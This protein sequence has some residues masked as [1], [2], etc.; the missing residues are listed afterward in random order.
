[1]RYLIISYDDYFN[2]P[3]IKFYEEYLSKH[4]HSYDIVLWNR[5]GQSVD[6]PNAFVFS[7]KDKRSKLG[8]ILPFLRW[9]RFALEV[10]QNQTYDR[11]I[12]LTTMPAVLLYDQLKGKY[13]GKFWFD[14][15]DFTYENI[16]FYKKLVGDLVHASG[17]VSISSPAF[18]TFLPDS[19]KIFLTHNISNTDS[20]EEHCTLDPHETPLRIGFVGGI[21][22]REQNQLLLK[23]FANNPDFILN[24]TGKAHLGCDL[25][26]FCEEN[27]I[28]NAEF[29]PA[30]T[31]DQ[32]PA[33]YRN[34]HLIN[35]VYGCNNQVVKLL[36]PNRLY[37]IFAE[38]IA[39]KYPQLEITFCVRGEIIINDAT[40]ADA[41]AVG[42]PFPVIDNGNRVPGTQLDML[43]QEALDAL[44]AADV[45]LAK[46]MANCETMFGCG[47]NVYYAFLVKC[48]R[49]VDRFQKP[50]L[51]PMLVRERT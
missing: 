30:F 27:G 17:A 12:L 39:K 22:F 41:E 14:I 20:M 50:M 51:T 49:F 1:M 44:N 47:Y 19:G 36:L 5:S 21:Q 15:R 40:R 10:L 34:I 18:R 7:A 32:K 6:L 13:R 29:F 3:Y 2:I 11:L 26:P 33:I 31:N 9:R 48:Q 45:I 46:G 43:G 28:Q 35:S 37:R 24:Y 23:Q 4:G 8:K 38:E 25:K 42:I 16:P